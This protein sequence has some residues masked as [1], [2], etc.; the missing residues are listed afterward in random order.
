MR[1]GVWSKGVEAVGLGV[2]REDQSRSGG[3]LRVRRD[4]LPNLLDRRGITAREQTECRRRG[5]LHKMC[6][7]VG[8]VVKV[9]GAAVSRCAGCLGGVAGCGGV[10]FMRIDLPFLRQQPDGCAVLPRDRSDGQGRA[11]KS[12]S[13][14]P[15][16]AGNAA[17]GRACVEVDGWGEVFFLARKSDLER[18]ADLCG[19]K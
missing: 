1:G 12:R 8:V 14:E 5:C 9:Q 17:M 13:C 10:M 18:Q 6:V 3:L 16:A 19:C 15:R 4:F 7:Y 11:F 2:C